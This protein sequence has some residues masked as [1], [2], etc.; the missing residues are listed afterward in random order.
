[1][2]Y[3]LSIQTNTKTETYNVT[4]R[5]ELRELIENEYQWFHIHS[6]HTHNAA[7]YELDEDGEYNEESAIATLEL[8]KHDD[9]SSE[10]ITEED[11]GDVTNTYS[12]CAKELF[13]ED[14]D[15][16]ISEFLNAIQ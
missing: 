4:T 7:L 3:K 13:T 16:S 12:R 8:P 9:F 1:M 6:V 2:T 10:E 15:G 5:E 11:D 14:Y